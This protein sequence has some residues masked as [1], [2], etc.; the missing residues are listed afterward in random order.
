MMAKI[1]LHRSQEDIRGGRI[2]PSIDAVQ[3]LKGRAASHCCL[4]REAKA[5]E[6]FT[7]NECGNRSRAPYFPSRRHRA[8]AAFVW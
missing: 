7:E 2:L 4:N 8:H 6:A 1:P 3:G 5:E